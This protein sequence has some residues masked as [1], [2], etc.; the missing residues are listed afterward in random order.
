MSPWVPVPTTGG[1]RKNMTLLSLKPLASSWKLE[2]VLSVGGKT[3][4]REKR[5][6]RRRGEKRERREKKREE[7]RKEG[8]E[9]GRKR[10]RKGG[11]EERRKGPGPHWD[12][13]ALELSCS[14]SPVQPLCAWVTVCGLLLF[15]YL[16]LLLKTLSLSVV[17]G[18][19]G[20]LDSRLSHIPLTQ[21]LLL[22]NLLQ[23]FITAKPRHSPFAN[24]T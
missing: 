1:T 24:W 19:P 12:S 9:G 23:R 17:Y 10:G 6:R 3:T 13:W 4:E 20:K 16:S 22:Q 11:R 8:R 7:G 2:A 18:S 15:T 5:R 14:A 21:A